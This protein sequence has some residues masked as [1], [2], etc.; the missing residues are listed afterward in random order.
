[1]NWPWEVEYVLCYAPLSLDYRDIG[2]YGERSWI[3]TSVDTVARFLVVSWINSW[4][5]LAVGIRI[6]TGCADHD[7]SAAWLKRNWIHLGYAGQ[8]AALVK[9]SIE[10]RA[11]KEK[12]Q[13]VPLGIPVEL[14]IGY[15]W[16][17]VA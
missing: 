7:R 15:R 3:S 10:S 17:A 13:G 9:R 4:N 8:L 2:I 6:H 11:A 16:L 12:S 14:C 1:M 5:L